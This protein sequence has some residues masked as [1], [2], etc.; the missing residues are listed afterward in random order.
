MSIFAFVRRSMFISVLS[1]VFL[2]VCHEPSARLFWDRMGKR[3]MAPLDTRA[4]D[5]SHLLGDASW[6]GK[7]RMQEIPRC[8]RAGAFRAFI[9]H[10]Y[11]TEGTRDRRNIL[12]QC[13]FCLHINRKVRMGRPARSRAGNVLM[14]TQ[15]VLRL[16]P[17]T[18]ESS[19]SGRGRS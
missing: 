17:P 14:L 4:E 15:N 9:T 6:L 11:F 19:S 7:T 2:K 13:S 10:N 3:Q 8:L 12:S 16:A 5:N 1:S 18:C